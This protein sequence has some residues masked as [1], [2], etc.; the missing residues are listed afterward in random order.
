MRSYF[1]IDSTW[2]TV[3]VAPNGSL[4]FRKF[5]RG[6]RGFSFLAGVGLRDLLTELLAHLQARASWGHREHVAAGNFFPSPGCHSVLMT[7][8]C[9]PLLAFT[10]WGRSRAVNIRRIAVTGKLKRIR[11]P[12]KGNN[13]KA[14][15][16]ASQYNVDTSAYRLPHLMIR[17]RGGAL[18]VPLRF[19]HEGGQRG[20]SLHIVYK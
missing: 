4:H 16:V 7:G 15:K 19:L 3:P 2:K 10:S 5:L 13:S 8:T 12:K 9:I 11:P 18:A 20:S 17:R 14:A 6:R 1:T